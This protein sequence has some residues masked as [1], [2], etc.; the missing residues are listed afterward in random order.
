MDRSATLHRRYPRAWLWH[1]VGNDSSCFLILGAAAVS[2]NF[3]VWTVR[4]SKFR[5]FFQDHT[6]LFW[7]FLSVWQLYDCIIT[8]VDIAWTL[9][10]FQ[11]F[12]NAL[13]HILMFI[14]MC[15][16]ILILFEL[17]FSVNVSGVNAI[18]FF[19]MLF[20]LFL[21]TFVALGFVL[22]SVDANPENDA[23]RSL[24]FWCACTDLILAIFFALPAPA[25]LDV[26]TAPMRKIDDVRCS[27]LCK[28]GTVL[29]VVLFGGRAIWNGS[30]YAGQNAV[31][32]WLYGPSA[33]TKDLAGNDRPSN[34]ARVISFVFIFFFD[35][36]TSL[37]SMGS[38]YL[39]KKH[40]MLFSETVYV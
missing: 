39:F 21:V 16:V 12:H 10:T 18:S 20:S 6:I 13:N 37:L 23:D 9:T 31:Q 34:E 4:Q 5:C 26:I 17:L 8:F 35:L 7:I 38:V 15:L 36:G 3:M 33:I 19:R 28:V 2:I 30:H 32:N 29:Y 24:A 1:S 40:D 11:F 22:S 14:P 27:M 25:L